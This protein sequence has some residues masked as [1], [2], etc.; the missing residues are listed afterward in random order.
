MVTPSI[1]MRK[2]RLGWRRPQ[3]KVSVETEARWAG[4]EAPLMVRRL[5]GSPAA[6]RLKAV[7]KKRKMPRS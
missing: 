2:L 5:V 3:S 1:Q 7:R 6:E 4:S